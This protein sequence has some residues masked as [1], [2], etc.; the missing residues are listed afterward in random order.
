M[1]EIRIEEGRI[2]IK[3]ENCPAC[4]SSN[5]RKLSDLL[6]CSDCEEV[7]PEVYDFEN[8]KNCNYCGYY[9]DCLDRFSFCPFDGVDVNEKLVKVW[10]Q[11]RII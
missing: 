7:F 6:F 2:V 9:G 5:V 3:S 8:P 10:M 11:T 1:D 4:G